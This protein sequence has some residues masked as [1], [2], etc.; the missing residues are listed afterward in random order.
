MGHLLILIKKHE[1]YGQEAIK[2]VNEGRASLR[3]LGE[4]RAVIKNLELSE[5]PKSN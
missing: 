1:N 2:S 5:K 4:F 3:S